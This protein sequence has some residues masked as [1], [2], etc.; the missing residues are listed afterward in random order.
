[1]WVILFLQHRIF[2]TISQEIMTSFGPDSP[3]QVVGLWRS[4][5]LQSICKLC[6]CS[7]INSFTTAVWVKHPS[8]CWLVH[9]SRI[10][11]HPF[12]RKLL[13]C[14]EAFGQLSPPLSLVAGNPLRSG[15]QDRILH[16][17]H[18]KDWTDSLLLKKNCWSIY[19]HEPDGVMILHLKT[20]HSS[21]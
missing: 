3:S 2:S 10:S 12:R 13:H 18:Q 5:C 14:A 1:M 11:P 19:E 16:G 4:V 7:A 20:K 15:L 8:V 21:Q 6:L 9:L 17:V